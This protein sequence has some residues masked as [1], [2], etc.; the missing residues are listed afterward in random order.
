M[1]IF[2]WTLVLSTIKVDKIENSKKINFYINKANLKKSFII[3]KSNIK[4]PI[5]WT[6]LIQSANFKLQIQSNFTNFEF[7]P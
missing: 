5:H 4:K 1:L 2:E 6:N 3:F 7:S